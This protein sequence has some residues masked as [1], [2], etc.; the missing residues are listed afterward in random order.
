MEIQEVSDKGDTKS[1]SLK[2]LEANREN[3]QRSTG[4]RT[5]AGKRYSRRNATRHGL[6]AS[7]GLIKDGLGAEDKAVFEKLWRA[8]RRNLQPI[9]QLE[10]MWVEEITICWWKKVRALR[11][12]TVLEHL[13]HVPAVMEFN[14][15]RT[16]LRENLALPLGPE[17]DQI[18]RYE[19]SN[20][21]QMS[22]ALNQLECLQRA[23]KGEHL[24]P[25]V[26]VHVTGDQG[27]PLP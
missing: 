21:R 24:P 16:A 2:K 23:R 15:E 11:C 19:A 7:A 25:P 22:F 1:I 26:N 12:E 17:L 18:L 14:A 9:G 3:A 8:L 4:P 27:P 10:E 20:Q 5:D 13:S 6:L